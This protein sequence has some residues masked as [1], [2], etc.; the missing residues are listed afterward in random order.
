MDKDYT[1]YTAD[2]LLNE[3]FFLLS[4][5]HPTKENQFFW[6]NLMTKNKSLA[7]EI[8]TARLFLNA[9]RANIDKTLL[10]DNENKILWQQIEQKNQWTDK[11]KR[12]KKLLLSVAGIAASICIL[13]SLG[14]YISYQPNK[15]E[16]NYLAIIEAIPEPDSSSQKV[17]LVLANNEKLTIDGEESQLEYKPG[18]TINVNSQKVEQTD[19]EEQKTTFNQLIV[20]VG[21]RS[22]ITFSDGTKIWVNSDSKVIYPVT[23]SKEKREIFVEGEIYLEV[24]KDEKRPFFVKT[25]QM[26]IKVLGT[27]FNVTAYEN[28]KDMQVVLVCGK[29]EVKSGNKHKDIL[30]P[31][32]MFRYDKEINKG[33]ISHVD[34]NDHVAWK[35][36]YYQF[37]QQSLKV[38]LKKLS[39]Y[40]GVQ[41]Y[42]G[43]EASTV[44]CSGKLDLKENL[45]DVLISLKKA[46]PIEIE[47]K[48]ES[49]EIKVKH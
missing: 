43:E 38:I 42:C 1:K 17:Q 22:T 28:E 25:R 7:A 37:K 21:K 24:S 48:H 39:R 26:D 20:P 4:E 31:N 12:Q 44:S 33:T 30:S 11:K 9:I 6:Q 10:P 15:Q 13:L 5:S 8:E 29:V 47:K 16:T 19:R 18:G 41:L 46:M 36:G 27:Q 34:I 2:Q 23:F 3:D 35:D 49:I 45:E 32:E 40:Y 14:K